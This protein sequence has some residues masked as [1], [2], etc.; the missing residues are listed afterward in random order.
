MFFKKIVMNIRDLTIEE[1][2]TELNAMS[3]QSYRA[4]QLFDWLHSKMILS[5]DE[6]TN[7]GNS[8]KK[9]LVEK[10]DISFPSTLYF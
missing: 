7:I 5:L 9:K 10:F 8:L 2:K 4:V 3:E 6:T 1:I